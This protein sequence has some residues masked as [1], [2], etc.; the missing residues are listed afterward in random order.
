M[1]MML[2]NEGVVECGT[3]VVFLVLGRPLQL[4]LIDTFD[5]RIDSALL[6]HQTNI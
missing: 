3:H 2:D 1:E 5:M 4:I 6:R